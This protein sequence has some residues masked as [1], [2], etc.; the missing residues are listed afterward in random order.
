MNLCPSCQRMLY[1]RRLAQCG[2]CGA[3]I[4]ESLQFTLERIAE[5]DQQMA[6]LEEQRRESIKLQAIDAMDRSMDVFQIDPPILIPDPLFGYPK[7]VYE[8]RL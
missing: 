3:A 5:I 8:E 1:D 6:E 2:Y 7:S 4:P